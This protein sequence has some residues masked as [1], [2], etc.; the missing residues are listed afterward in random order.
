M[1]PLHDYVLVEKVDENLTT[2][3]GLH[4]LNS[5]RVLYKGKI[6]DI[7]PG[8]NVQYENNTEAMKQI[9]VNDVVYFSQHSG[10][11][12]EKNKFLLRIYELLAKD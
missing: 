7:G 6:L 1:K 5:D 12:I 2:K 10:Y 3:G 11:E 4:L 9:S 8:K